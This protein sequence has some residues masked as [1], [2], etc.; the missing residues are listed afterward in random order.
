MPQTLKY[1][2]LGYPG[3]PGN[4]FSGSIQ[5]NTP[6]TL[7]INDNWISDLKIS[8]LN[9]LDYC[10]LSNNPL[11]G[12]SNLAVLTSRC[13]MNGLYAASL[14]PKTVKSK[15]SSI[16]FV[17][18]R[19][20]WKV[21]M[22]SAFT[23]TYIATNLSL[24]QTIR[25]NVGKI[26]IRDTSKVNVNVSPQLVESVFQNRNLI[27]LILKL[28]VD[29]LILGIVVTQTPFGREWDKENRESRKTERSLF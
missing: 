27:H 17:A 2:W 28:M 29:S 18:S 20:S 9:F 11:L 15:T 6:F 16:R 5:L 1:I 3:L 22:N 24:N 19:S 12:N 26:Q 8:N 10:D 21:F 7:Y 23:S 4:H 25:A 13:T 14:L